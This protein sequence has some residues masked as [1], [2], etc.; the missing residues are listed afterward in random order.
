[1]YVYL[2]CRRHDHLCIPVGL[3]HY[4]NPQDGQTLL[5]RAAEGCRSD[6]ITLLLRTDEE[7]ANIQDNFGNTA[8][9]I[10]CRRAHKQ[11][12]KALL[13]NCV[14]VCPTYPTVVVSPHHHCIGHTL[15]KAFFFFICYYFF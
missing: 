11:T 2:L 14:L 13:V 7:L 9:Q 5:H 1:M 8:L 10:A 12:V 15:N 6:N 3:V 4:V